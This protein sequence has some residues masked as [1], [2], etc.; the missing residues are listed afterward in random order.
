MRL[1]VL[2]TNV[3]VHLIRDSQTWKFIDATYRPLDMPNQL[4]HQW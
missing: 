1:F 4:C 2:D 3:V